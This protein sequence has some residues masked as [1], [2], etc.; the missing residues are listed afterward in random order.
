MSSVSL[1]SIE[2]SYGPNL[3]VKGIDLDVGESEF[4]V[5]VGPSGCGKSTTLR[6]IAGLEE[7]SAGK[8]EI[9]QKECTFAPPSERG[10]AMVFQDYA[11]YPHMS[12]FENMAFG[13]RLKKLSEDEIQKRV[14][15]AADILGL[16]PVLERKPAALSGGQRQRV[17]MGRAFVKQTGVYLF[18]EPLSNLDAK[19]RAKMRLE[20]KKF[21]REAG[22]SIIYVTHDQLEAMTLADRIVVMNAGKIEQVGAPLEVF[23]CPKTQFVASFIG[24]PQMNFLSGKIVFSG[25]TPSF[26][27]AVSKMRF[28]LPNGK[29]TKLENNQRVILGLRPSD[30]YISV[31]DHYPNWQ[32]KAQVEFVEL[33]GKN[34]YITFEAAGV[35]LVGEVMG[36]DIPSI[37]S[38]KNL[39]LN[40]NHAHLFD[41]DTKFNLLFNA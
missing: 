25:Q 32:M 21:H 10:V 37:G 15:K 27:C 5:L 9:N 7:I 18:D 1:K 4:V 38:T 2:K 23:D 22:G 20:M 40:L 19:L 29:F 14:G 12:V 8:L 41:A 24:S 31:D 13:L 11:L 35:S 16:G 30:L 17:A 33:L 6:M 28:E 39:T 3:I 26:E 34:A 36:R